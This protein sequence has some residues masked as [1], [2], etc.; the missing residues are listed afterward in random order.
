MKILFLG[1][2][3]IGQRHLRNLNK[4]NKSFE[5]YAI[6]HLKRNFELNNNN[7]IIG[8]DLLNKYKIKEIN[9]IED[10]INI[11]IK[12]VFINTPSSKHLDYIEIFLK[13]KIHIF[14]EKP[15][16]DN[17]KQA[18]RFKKLFLK[19]KNQKIM[20]GHQLRFNECLIKIKKLIKT[21]Q[22]GKICGANI[23]HG[24]NINNFHTYEDYKISYAAKKKLGGGVIL[25]Q[26][27]EIDYCLFLFGEPESV[28]A[29]GGKKSNLKIDVEDYTNS[30]ITFNNKN[31]RFSVSLTLDYLQLPKKRELFITGSLAS[32]NWNYY[33]DEIVVNFYNGKVKKYNYKLKDRN[34]L[35]IKELKHFLYTI[36]YNKNN[37]ST[38]TE[39]LQSLKLA[40]RIKKSIASNKMI[41]F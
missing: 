7:Q 15:L 6:R 32:L 12:I 2:G 5:I 9:S 37:V 20:I 1:L 30:F 14:I 23:Y 4:I 11:G 39:A 16:T 8:Y 3:S 33:Q 26:I 22:L 13:N 34:E 21:N 29:T 31:Q 27:H 35:F 17:L 41:K 38:Y 36:K 24:E 10:A 19:D 25:S 18:L 40:D 28:Y